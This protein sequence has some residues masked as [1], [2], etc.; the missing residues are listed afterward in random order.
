MGVSSVKYMGSK[1]SMLRNG[2]GTILDREIPQSS[3][4]IDLFT[5]S[6]AVATYVSQKF[7]IPVLAFDLQHYSS[8][9]AQA[10]LQRTT[11]LSVEPAWSN[12][13][14]EAVGVAALC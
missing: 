6:A 10:I 12:W 11:S 4:F 3:R 7:A 8:T 9:L 5:G 13:L 14:K 2:L 1:T